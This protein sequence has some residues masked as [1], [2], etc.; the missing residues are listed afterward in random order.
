MGMNPT[1][2]LASLRRRLRLMISRAVIKTVNDG[3]KLQGLQ[4][5][6]LAGN[7]ADD[8]EHFQHYGFTSVPEDGAEAIVL[9]INGHLVVIATGDRRHRKKGMAL[10]EVAI[11]H[12]DGSYLWLKNN[13]DIDALATGKVKLKGTTGVE[14]DG[15]TGTPMGIVQA[16]CLCA[17][18]G[19]KHPMFSTTTKASL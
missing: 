3:L 4:I 10:G 18:T 12:K 2:I 11:Y 14:L 15:G 1:K 7:V 9:N 19:Q 13:G 17:F 5:T 16:D 6:L 8:V